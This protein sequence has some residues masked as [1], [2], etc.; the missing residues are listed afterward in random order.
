MPALGAAGLLLLVYLIAQIGVARVATETR[1]LSGVL[2]LILALT[3]GKYLLQTAGWRLVLPRPLRPRWGE[4]LS[5][6]ITGDALGYLTWAGPFTGEPVR[7]LLVRGSVPVAAGIAAGAVERAMYNATA[8]L[9]VLTVALALLVAERP[10]W[11]AMTATAVLA[12]GAIVALRI[13]AAGRVRLAGKRGDPGVD[14]RDRATAALPPSRVAR[15]L[16][17]A[18]GLWRERRSI[19]P[20]LTVLCLAQHAVLVAEAHVML[21]VLG[22]EASVWTAF[23]FEAVTK[24]VNTA[25]LIVPARVGVSEGG[26][27]LLAGAL[28]FAASHGLS[29]ALMRRIRTFIWAAVGLI[30]L[31]VQESRARAARR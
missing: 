26:S 17:A 9:L 4:A 18:R 8:A 31:P 16:D 24:L 22:G 3:G 21:N 1:R 10:V 7:A 30:L 23:V 15:V 5:A 25:G 2:P 11:L 19:L 28:G 14:R 20:A 6:T 12:T 13:R 29:L 27:A